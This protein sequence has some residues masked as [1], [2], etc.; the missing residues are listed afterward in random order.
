MKI[1]SLQTNYRIRYNYYEGGTFN[2]R[3]CDY[4]GTGVFR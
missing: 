3:D 2:L 1:V 4:V